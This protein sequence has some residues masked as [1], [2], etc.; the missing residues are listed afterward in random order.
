[1][2][3]RSLLSRSAIIVQKAEHLPASLAVEFNKVLLRVMGAALAKPACISSCLLFLQSLPAGLPNRGLLLLSIRELL[4]HGGLLWCISF[5]YFSSLKVFNFQWGEIKE[6]LF[7]F[8]FPVF[9]LETFLCGPVRLSLWLSFHQS[10]SS[11]SASLWQPLI[12]AMP[13]SISSTQHR[14]S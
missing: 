9:C 6:V 11:V 4:F 1:M 12:S 10:V 5:L 3:R 2:W 13:N 14:L 8:S 7:C